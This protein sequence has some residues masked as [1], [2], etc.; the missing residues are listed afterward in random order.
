MQELVG[1]LTALDPEASETLRVVGYFDALIASGVGLDG[2]LRAAAA[3]SAAVAGAE[4][5]GRV[6]R[7]DPTGRRLGD[8]EAIVRSPER[9]GSTFQVWLEREGALH[10]NDEMVVERLTLAVELLE[11]RN[12]PAS[13]LDAALDPSA[14][15][16]DRA[17]ALARLRVGTEA[18]IRLIATNVSDPLP[19]MPSTVMATRFG[20]L[21]ASLDVSGSVSPPGRAGLGPWVRADHAPA[22]WD[23]AVIAHRLTDATDPVVDAELLGAMLLLAL[24]HDPEHPHD[25]VTRLHRLDALEAAILRALVEADSIRAASSALGMHHSSIQS[26]HEGLTRELGYDPRTPIGRARYVAATILLRL[27]DPAPTG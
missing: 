25:D 7:F 19:G 22:S 16:S 6:S 3:L 1:R 2:L 8:A 11:A 24:A 21:R 15:I 12:G 5:R 23:G 20:M 13:G 17:A 10:A 18:R 26:R 9:S 27:T 4:R 14:P